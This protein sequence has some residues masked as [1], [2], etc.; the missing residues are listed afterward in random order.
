ME[1][2]RLGP[3][4]GLGTW[5]TFGGDAALAERVV[6]A[7]LN[8]GSPLVDTSPMYG[9]AEASLA[10]ALAGRRER[11]TVATKIWAESAAEG[12]E[13]FRRQLA[14]YGRV[15][16]EQIHNLAAW[17]EQ[18]R[19]LEGERDAGRIGRLGVTHYSAGAFDELATAMRT[20]RFEVVQLPLNPLQRES[21][22]VLLPLAAELG[23]AVIVM[24]PLASGS[25]LRRPRAESELE[26]LREFGVRS[27][28]QALLKWVLSDERVDAVIPATS[29]PERVDE[30]AA[31]GT[32]P[33]LGPDE[34]RL[35]ERLA[36]ASTG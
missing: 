9:E 16:V 34:R 32:P 30:N 23:L 29:K 21:E 35:V 19:W 14:W 5:R 17:R 25:L 33:W 4:V 12:R 27:W 10:S 31:A 8:A 7:A 1:E 6:G 36:S 2:R 15:D 24:S 22:R 28:A 18:L 11:M 26:P 3:V 20:G 13:Q